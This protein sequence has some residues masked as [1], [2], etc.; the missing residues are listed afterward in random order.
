M[1]YPL[2]TD[3]SFASLLAD[4]NPRDGQTVHVVIQ[5]VDEGEEETLGRTF[6]VELED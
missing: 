2:L 1:E 6:K 5:V 4:L 3:A